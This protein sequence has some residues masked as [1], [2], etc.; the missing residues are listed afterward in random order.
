MAL[1]ELNSKE[2][3]E[4]IIMERNAPAARSEEEM[5][6]TARTYFFKPGRSV[7]HPLPFII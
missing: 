6:D 7:T 1:R 2:Y 4:E 3:R 5:I